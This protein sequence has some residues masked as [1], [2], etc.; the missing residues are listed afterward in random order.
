L[1][2]VP[3]FLDSRMRHSYQVFKTPIRNNPAFRVVKFGWTEIL[4]LP[5]VGID[6]WFELDPVHCAV[7]ALILEN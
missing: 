5:G 4:D 7:M 1:W 3:V 6:R 2:L